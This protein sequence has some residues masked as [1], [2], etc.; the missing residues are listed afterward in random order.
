MMY[1]IYFM[2]GIILRVSAAEFCSNVGSI[3]DK[4]LQ[5]VLLSEQFSQIPLPEM[6]RRVEDLFGTSVALTG[7]RLTGLQ[8]IRRTGQ[9]VFHAGMSG[10]RITFHIKG[11]PLEANFVGRLRTLFLRESIRVGAR[12]PTF[13]AS[14]TAEERSPNRVH[15]QVHGV[16]MSNL[17][18]RLGGTNLGSSGFITDLIKP[19]IQE[20]IG[21]ILARE[22]RKL[23]EKTLGAVK[24]YAAKNEAA[25]DPIRTW[26]K[27]LNGASAYLDVLRRLNVPSHGDEEDSAEENSEEDS[28]YSSEDYSEEQSSYS[29]RRRWAPRSAEREQWVFDGCLRTLVVSTGFEPAPL[30]RDLETFNCSFGSVSV[31]G[32]NVTGLSNVKTRGENVVKLGECGLSARFDLRFNDLFVQGMGTVTSGSWFTVTTDFTFELRIPAVQAILEITERYNTLEITNYE[33]D[34]TAPVNVTAKPLGTV[35]SVANFFGAAPERALD[36]NE[37]EQLKHASRKYVQQVVDNVAL[38][39]ADPPIPYR[40]RTPRWILP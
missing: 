14:F 38:F 18:L 26:K 1:K 9:S 21:E 40:Y 3:F 32:G 37:L 31:S 17:R 27:A 25:T 19:S 5:K 22:L 13:Q 2:F 30:P 6:N 10:S 20:K 11:G 23:A 24:V 15:L 39:I 29:R 35:G 8:T 34:F 33:L 28:E 12:V 4:G 16:R 7:G 36:V